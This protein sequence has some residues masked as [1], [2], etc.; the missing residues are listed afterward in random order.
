MGIR[1][2]QLPMNGCCSLELDKSQWINDFGSN[3][4]IPTRKMAEVITIES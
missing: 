4:T 1:V 2:R 3:Y